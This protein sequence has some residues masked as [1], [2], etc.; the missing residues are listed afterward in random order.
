MNR[1]K[2]NKKTKQCSHCKSEIDVLATKCPQCQSDLRSWPM[3]HLFLLL[4]GVIIIVTILAVG[5]S[6]YNRI[7]DKSGFNSVSRGEEGF[8]RVA[9][10]K[11]ILVASTKESLDR[12]VNAAVSK[13]NY[14]M[15]EM[16]LSGEAFFVDTGI[17]VL[18]IESG[19]TSKRI[20]ILEGKK[21]GYSGWVPSEFVSLQ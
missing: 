21:T 12:L 6:F 16:V 13:D 18:V 7:E 11:E 8:L 9:G 15:G 19:L 14:G 3:R 5:Q 20:R 4:M 17:K 10:Q 1:E 2:E